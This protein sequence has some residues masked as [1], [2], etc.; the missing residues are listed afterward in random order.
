MDWTGLLAWSINQKNG[1]KFDTSIKPM[2]EETKKWLTE[3]LQSYSVDEFQM[4]KD[5]LDKIAK[6][7]QENEEEQR[8][9]WFEQLMELLDALDRANDFCKIGG[10]NLMF[11][12]YQ[13]T[14]FDSIKLQALK[15]IA[16]CNQNNAF[17]Q[18]YCGENDY[19]KI[20]NEIEKID[21]LKLKEQVIS[22]LSSMIRGECLNNKRKF[23]DMN[24]I[25]LL[26]NH[27]DSNRCIEKIANLFRD[28][29]YYDDQLHKTYHDL[30][31]FSNTA[32]QTIKQQDKK[33]YNLTTDINEELLKS[34]ELPQNLK[35]KGIVKNILIDLK[36]LSYANKFIFDTSI[37]NS[38][39][40]IQYLSCSEI[41]LKIK[42]DQEFKQIIQT[43]LE[44]LLKEQDQ[45]EGEINLCKQ[46]L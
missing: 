2:D 36:F 46:I 3:A 43:H 21:N 33:N 29:L 12:Y 38:D 39:L 37:K 26:L 17:V 30:S 23:I 32:G 41:L 8:L 15:I 40:R 25:Q 31:K 18:E 7:E 13:T 42:N 5:L 16:N 1:E 24:G 28:L 22:A 4:I 27:L 44:H 6:P 9:E 34:N 45:D 10:L 20:V 14:K 35:Y 11:N 19:L